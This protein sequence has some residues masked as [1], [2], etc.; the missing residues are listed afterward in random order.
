VKT[1]W[2]ENPDADVWLAQMYQESGGRADVCSAVGACG[3]AQFMPKTW[4][5]MQS[6]FG[7]SKSISRFEP[8]Y[9]IE[10]GVRYQ[11]QQRRAWGAE[12]RTWT[13]RNELGQA[14]YNA[15]LGNI[16]KAQQRCNGARLVEGVLE[17]LPQVTGE[18][19]AKETRGYI[20]NIRK[21]ITRIRAG[22]L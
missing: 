9:A 20:I 3:L 17:C 16:L 1:W 11:G 13:Q 21:W 10:A 19:N 4:E 6:Q 15:G 8:K 22:L 14:S 2:P 5:D 12:G 18:D 7:W